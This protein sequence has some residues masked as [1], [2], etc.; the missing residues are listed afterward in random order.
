MA[1]KRQLKKRISYVCGDL[2]A[3]ILFA[4]RLFDG[5]DR[6]KVNEI[7]N[8]IAA[9]Q[10]DSR[11]KVSF[12]FDKSPRDFETRQAYRAARAAYNAA[13]FARLREEFSKRAMEIVKQMNEAV[14]A[15]VRKALTPQ[16]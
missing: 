13:A 16:A 12:S 7:V 6:G 4:A 9:L 5:I 1:N 11:A 14:P 15:D 8:E 2:A 10:E 3:D